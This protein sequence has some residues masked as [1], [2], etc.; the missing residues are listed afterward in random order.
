MLTNDSDYLDLTSSSFSDE[1][2]EEDA[3]GDKQNPFV[4]AAEPAKSKK[5][6]TPVLDNFGK[7]ITVLATQDKLDPVVGKRKRNRTRFSNFK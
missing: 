3:E 2:E 6:K 1:K 4:P 5:S 7:D